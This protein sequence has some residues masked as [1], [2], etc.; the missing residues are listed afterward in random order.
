MSDVPPP[1]AVTALIAEAGPLAEG[2]P[3]AETAVLVARA[4]AGAEVDSETLAISVRAVDSARALA[5]PMLISM[6]LDA[7]TA[8]HLARG[9]FDGARERVDT[10]TRLPFHIEGR[11]LAISRRLKVDALAGDVERVLADAE[12]FRQ[13]WLKAGQPV[14]P[15][16]AGGAY[17]VA[18]VHGLRGDAEA[19]ADWLAI[20][21]E[22]GAD[23]STNAGCSLAWAPTFDAILALHEGDPARAVALMTMH[24]A[25]LVTWDGGEWRPWYAALWAEAAVLAGDPAADQRLADARPL[26]APNPIAAAMVERAAA[27]AAGEVDRLVEAAATQAE[28]GCRYQAARTLILAGGTHAAEGRAAMATLGAAPMAEPAG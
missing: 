14:T 11:H 13:G 25:E 7:L 9:D 15:T 10:N 23:V 4:F 17:A 18:M 2:S 1:E 28:A 20:T 27:L 6:A 5:D 16:L 8:C 12:L 21:A 22:L 19:R 24:P 3:A 26:V